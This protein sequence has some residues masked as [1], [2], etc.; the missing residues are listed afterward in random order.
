MDQRP[1]SSLTS[2]GGVVELAE[3]IGH[4]GGRDGY[5]PVGL[6]LIDEVADQGFD[7]AVEDQTDDFA[8][9]VDQGRAGVPAGDVVGGHE[10][11]R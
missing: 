11:E 10:V 7:I 4:G 9:P 3:G 1:S 5:R 8:F 2:V 6:L